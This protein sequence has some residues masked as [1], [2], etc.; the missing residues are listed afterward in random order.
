MLP[1]LIA[2][3]MTHLGHDA[4]IRHFRYEQWIP[5]K[6]AELHTLFT[7][8]CSK[9]IERQPLPVHPDGG[10]T[11]IEHEYLIVLVLQLLNSGN[12][13][14]RQ[15]EWVWLAARRV[16][17]AAAPVAR[18]AVGQCVLCR[19]RQPDGAAAAPAGAARR[20]RAVP[21]HPRAAS[22]L[23]QN[24]VVIEQKIKGQPLSTKT[25]RRS[26]QLNLLTKLASQVDPEFRPF[27]RRGERS[28]A[29]GSVDAIVGLA[30]ISGYLREE[31]RAP[32][33]AFD[34][35]KSFGGTME[36][37]V[38]GRARD[39]KNRRREQA[40]LRLA[41]FAA[42]GGP[43]EVKDVSQTGFRLLAPMS[44]AGAV[45]LGTLTA[46]RPQ[47]AGDVVARHRRG[48]CAA[49]RRSAPRSGCR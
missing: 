4:R 11:T 7:L 22:L 29:E 6:W 45:T 5:A 9:Q 13:S 15:L 21:R 23:L 14:A 2:R 39:E 28:S 16:V 31:E 43:W 42:P 12:L 8:A 38:F 46:I 19:S 30:R 17:P 3:Q 48:A 26:E 47:R 10:T 24:V 35:A 27:A 44:A 25:A 18:A 36:L 33:P 1:E 49:S 37:A 32:I 34:I 40:T 20:P 41:Q